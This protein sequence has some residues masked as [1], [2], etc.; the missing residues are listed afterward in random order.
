MR[1]RKYGLI[2]RLEIFYRETSPLQTDGSAA[3]SQTGL[4]STVDGGE[5]IYRRQLDLEE[6]KAIEYFR[7]GSSFFVP[8]T[9]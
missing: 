8:I 4:T 6:G 5:A 9:L 1:C 7:D 2:I 3:G